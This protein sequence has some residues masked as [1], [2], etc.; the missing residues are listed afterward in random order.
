[1][2][3]ISAAHVWALEKKRTAVAVADV[4][5]YQRCAV[6]SAPQDRYMQEDKTTLL[7]RNK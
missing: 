7:K 1:V 5:T 4:A 2:K 3:L 6:R